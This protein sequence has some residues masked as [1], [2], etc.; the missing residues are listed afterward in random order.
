M[1]LH[2]R[3]V[4]GTHLLRL[5]QQNGVALPKPGVFL[6]EKVPQAGTRFHI[7]RLARH[8]LGK[9]CGVDGAPQAQE[10]AA[11]GGGKPERPMR[12]EKPQRPD[13]PERPFKPDRPERPVKPERPQ[14]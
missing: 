10:R 1:R 6:L 7:L 9:R 4:L 14:R 8:E 11:S 13:K 3:I 2:S 12:A 5:R